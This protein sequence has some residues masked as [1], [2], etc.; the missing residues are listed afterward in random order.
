MAVGEKIIS[1]FSGAAD[2]DSFGFYIPPP[3]EKTHKI[4][5][6]KQ[7]KEL[8]KLYEQAD[9]LRSEDYPQDIALEI[10]NKVMDCCPDEWLLLQELREQLK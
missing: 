3:Q 4:K 1:T 5:Y 9:A 6:S 7:Q 10:H 2:P 8:F